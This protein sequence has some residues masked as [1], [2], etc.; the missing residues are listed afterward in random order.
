MKR[1]ELGATLAGS[2]EIL[3]KVQRASGVSLSDCYQC[4]KCSAGC[5]VAF[6]MDYTPRQI[7]RLLQFG[8]VEEA[9]QSHTI[10]LCAH[11]NACFTRCPREIDLPGLLETLRVE[12]KK[13]GLIKEKKV[14]LF[15]DLFLDSVKKHGRVHEMGMILKF[16]LKAGQPFK[17][18]GLAPAL[19]KNGKLKPLPHKIHDN[20]A[21][22]R[23]FERINGDGGETH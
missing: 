12:A 5:P 19:Y 15:T 16:N 21:V 10:W 7:I 1:Y 20:G 18:A 13:A 17:D 2:K 23:I 9:L 22:K 4:G 6:A 8:L 14:D 3:G 11:C